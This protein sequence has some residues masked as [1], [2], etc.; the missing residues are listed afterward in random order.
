MCTAGGRAPGRARGSRHAACR[1]SERCCAHARSCTTDKEREDSPSGAFRSYRQT[2][3][4][5]PFNPQYLPLL[6]QELSPAEFARFCEYREQYASFRRG[7]A[8]GA[9]GEPKK[10]PELASDGE[11]DENAEGSGEN[12]GYA[13]ELEKAVIGLFKPPALQDAKASMGREAVLQN[14]LREVEAKFLNEQ[15]VT[16]KGVTLDQISD[17]FR[18]SSVP[19]QMGSVDTYME[20][21][22]RDTVEDSVHCNAP[23]MIGHMTM[24]LPYYI[25]PMAKLV[26][27]MHQNNVKTET[28]KTTTFI[29][30]EVLAMLHR[31]LFA[32]SDA[33]YT[34]HA[35][36]PSTALGLVCSGGTLANV[37]ALWLARNGLMR[38]VD[39]GFAGV[40][41]EGMMK[42]MRHYGYE[43]AVFIGTKLLHY[44]MKKAADVLGL[45]TNGMRCV[46][47][48]DNYRV[49]TDLMEQEILACRESKT[50]IIALIGV[51]GATETGSVDDL[52]AIAN[53]AKKYGCHF[54]VDAA[55]GGPCIF[56]KEKAQLMK[57]I[58]RADTVTLDGHKQLYTPMGCGMCLMRD[59]EIIRFVQKTANYII[60]KESHD[61]GKFTIEGSRPATV[62][63][64]HANLDVLGVEGYEV[65]IDRSC[66]L[67]RYMADK[68]LESNEAELVVDPQTNIMLYRF[69]PRSMEEAC[70]SK[71]LTEAQQETI[72]EFNR[73]I[74]TEQKDRGSTFVSRTTIYS[75]K[76]GRDVVALRV[77]IA[78]P[79][80]T[81][82]DIDLNVSDQLAILAELGGK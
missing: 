35:Q 71:S 42:A 8:R 24:S 32:E 18:K 34:E 79:L 41:K 73:K 63:F 70:R 25:R 4:E 67:V 81:E 33:F 5:D 3:N 54:H 38:P 23:S 68:I 75:P 52:D 19:E 11:G 37:S 40:E 2:R 43:D 13:N 61:T 10:R 50:A 60:R 14:R 46:P 9:K 56:S 12:G 7:H 64:M 77:V 22:V 72:D 49:K 26:T 36:N 74:Q 28:G 30:R 48:D 51:A 80:T 20:N 78:N 27:A 39:G 55:W 29:E 44:S 66:R 31:T 82:A 6:K 65:L 58:E 17:R 53:L 47:F 21:F 59:P 76:H 15:Q 45:G 1:P 16:T 62:V 57:G 69:V